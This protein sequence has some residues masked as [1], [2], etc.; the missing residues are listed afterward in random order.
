MDF[1]SLTL[2]TY[3]ITLILTQADGPYGLIYKLRT[4]K[5]VDDFGLLNCYFCTALWVA[6]FLCLITGNLGLFF[7]AWGGATIID[8]VVQ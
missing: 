3:A 7:I 8:K 4:I 2:G 1:I 6:L 5:Q